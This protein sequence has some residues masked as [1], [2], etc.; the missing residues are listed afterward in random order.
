MPHAQLAERF[1]PAAANLDGRGHRVVVR[2]ARAR[3]ADGDAA[4]AAEF[5]RDAALRMRDTDLETLAEAIDSW[6]TEGGDADSLTQDSEWQSG[7][8]TEAQRG[9]FI[10]RATATEQLSGLVDD[11]ARHQGELA[12]GQPLEEMPEAEMAP[13]QMP[14]LPRPPF[15]MP[16]ADVAADE[17]PLSGPPIDLDSVPPDAI[18]PVPV[19]TDDKLNQLPG[20]EAPPALVVKP[21][22]EPKNGAGPVISLLLAAGIAGAF[23]WYYFLR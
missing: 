18:T 13:E 16:T 10:Q 2:A 15:S 7:V 21:S 17:M 22:S 8:A 1:N 9:L 6:L 12:S 14:P 23:F 11:V 20:L 3:V 19:A 5:L 4:G